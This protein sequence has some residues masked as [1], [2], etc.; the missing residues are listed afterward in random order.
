MWLKSAWSKPVVHLL[1]LLPLAG[2]VWAGFND[3]LGAN[4]VEK[5]THET[6][7]W[8]LRFLLITLSLTPL[9]QW[10]GQ[11]SWIRFRRMLG[12]YTFFYVS[13]HFLIWFVADHSLDPGSMIE[14]IV[15]RPYITLGFSAFL[16]MVPLAITSNQAMI[17]R[18]GRKWKTLHRLVYLIILLGV[19]HFLWLVKADYLEPGIYAIIAL[20]L[21]AHRIGPIKRPGARSSPVT[22]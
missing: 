11:A 4:P 6:G 7:D 19:L 20:I 8:T 21:L 14:D 16:L 1:C 17:R 10:T 15:K 22:R 12:L 13:C 5:L 3:G 18:L 2:L 9:R